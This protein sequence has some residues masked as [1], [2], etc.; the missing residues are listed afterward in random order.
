MKNH[1]IVMAVCNTCGNGFVL[2]EAGVF[3]TLDTGEEVTVCDTCMGIERDK[4]GNAWLPEWTEI[5]WKDDTITT[6]AE[7]FSNQNLGSG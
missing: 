3:T 5:L 2:G 1:K 7:A 6:R 4:D